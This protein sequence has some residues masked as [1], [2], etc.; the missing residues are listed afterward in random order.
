MMT[1][2]YNYLLTGDGVYW[3]AEEKE[4][5]ME[6]MKREL[7]EKEGS[8]RSLRTELD[9]MEQ[10]KVKKER[11]FDLLRQSMRIMNGKRSSVQT[12]QKLLKSKRGR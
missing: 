10:E 8:I 2:E 5:H 4:I 9:S 1:I 7:Q 3:K 12:K 11:E 6:N